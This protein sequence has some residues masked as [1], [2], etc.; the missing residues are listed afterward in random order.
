MHRFEADAMG[1]VP[2]FMRL[3]GRW[4]SRSVVVPT[5]GAQRNYI[6]EAK[7]PP[8]RRSPTAAA[9]VETRPAHP[10][11]STFL[12]AH[13][14]VSVESFSGMFPSQRGRLHE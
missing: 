13:L 12:T 9:G 3:R 5:A 11:S 8:H 1:F 14:F 2:Y 4:S 6:E 7:A 10:T